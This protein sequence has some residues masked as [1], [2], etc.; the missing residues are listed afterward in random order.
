MSYLSLRDEYLCTKL[1]VADRY[2]HTGIFLVLS[3]VS[4]CFTSTT[5]YHN[6]ASVITLL[7]LHTLLEEIAHTMQIKYENNI[8]LTNDLIMVR[9]VNIRY[10]TNL[11]AHHVLT[12]HINIYL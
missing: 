9:S 7:C 12:V 4:I 8:V 1:R 6:S 5:L 2:Y 11:N 10:N 3:Y